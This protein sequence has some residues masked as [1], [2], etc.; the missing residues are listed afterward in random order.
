[1]KHRHADS[2]FIITTFITFSL[3]IGLFPAVSSPITFTGGYTKVNLEEGYKSMTLSGG[4]GVNTDN[5]SL[6]ADFIELYGDNYRYVSCEGNVK[7]SETEKGI[8]FSSPKLFYDRTNETVTSDSW[9]EIQ[10]NKNQVSLSGARFEYDMQKSFMNL[11]M[12]SKIIKVTDEGLMICRADIIEYDGSNNT[13]KLKG[14]ASVNWNGNS[15]S[16]VMIAIDLNTNG[17]TMY[18]DISGEFNA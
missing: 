3:L 18:G 15:Y 11:Q 2:L 8:S 14:N 4:A 5:I 9:I 1:M 16:A 12:A 7:A 6:T 10:D 17:I 13:V